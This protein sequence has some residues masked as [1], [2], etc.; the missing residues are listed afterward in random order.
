MSE[1]AWGTPPPHPFS[2][3]TYQRANGEDVE[4]TFDRLN[5]VP[6][7]ARSVRKASVYS[8]GLHGLRFQFLR[9][10]DAFIRVEKIRS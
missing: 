8:R 10:Y 5:L 1:T 3:R 2:A 9:G 6:R 4:R 7:L